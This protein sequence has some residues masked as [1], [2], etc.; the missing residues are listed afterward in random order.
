MEDDPASLGK[1]WIKMP[2]VKKQLSSFEPY[3]RWQTNLTDT[4][5]ID[6]NAQRAFRIWA[7]IT[8]E[9]DCWND[10]GDPF[11]ELFCYFDA[12][13]A[14]YLP[15]YGPTDYVAGIFAFNTTADNM[16]G[17]LGLLGFSDDNWIDGT[18]SY[19]FAFDTDYY[20]SIGYGFSTTTVHEAGHHFGMSHPHDGYD[21]TTGVDYGAS[22]PYYFVNSGDE[23]ATIMH[24]MDLSAGFSQFDRDNMYRWE[25]AGYLNWSNKLLADILAD[26]GV[27]KVKSNI[28][29]AQQDAQRANDSFNH[30]NY[31]SAVTNAKNAY[32]DLSIAAA[33]LGITPPSAMAM[34]IAPNMVAPHEGDPIRFPDN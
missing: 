27:N 9:D 30:W 32:E 10:Y 19:V 26:P 4:N 18:Q 28:A 2:F 6:A 21:S 23:S 25:M 5:P 3:Y 34:R 17:Q 24:Y 12:N 20:R 7:G 13:R 31:L 15:T 29:N 8:A 22:G 16:G 33:K 14:A 1:D 11:A